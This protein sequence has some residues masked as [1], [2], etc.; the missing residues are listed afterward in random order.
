MPRHY[1]DITK[2]ARFHWHPPVMRRHIVGAM[3]VCCQ[4]EKESRVV[5]EDLPNHTI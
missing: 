3:E 2:R 1:S 4:P 5:E